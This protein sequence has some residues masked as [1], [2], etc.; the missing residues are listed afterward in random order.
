M[1]MRPLILILVATVCLAGLA[2]AQTASVQ[3]IHNS[4]DPLAAAVDVYLGSE[5][6][7]DDFAFRTA[8]PVLSLPAET[9][10][11][12]GI[13]P[14]SSAGPQ[15]ILATFPVTLTA[16]GSYVVM[17]TGVLD[18]TL[19]GNPEG[20]DTAFTLKIFSPLTTTAP[21]GQVALLAYH[22]APDAPTV[23]ILAD[24]VGVLVPGLSY[25]EFAGYLA[26]PAAEYILRVTPAGQNETIVASF[27]A[28]LTDLGGGA[29]VVFASGFLSSRPGS[30][31]GLY[32]A[33]TDG[34]VLELVAP[35]VATSGATWGEMKAL[36]E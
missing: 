13:A 26:V 33:L 27:V 36:Y 32:A 17:A 21:A 9:E 8:T 12:I 18:P 29:A 28:P 20:L 22:G 16:G 31:F 25:G 6:A 3:I 1:T 23:D 24:G 35:I 34:T 5:L 15:D 4:P 14:G 19:P 30:P 11:V 7:V 2:T 10:L